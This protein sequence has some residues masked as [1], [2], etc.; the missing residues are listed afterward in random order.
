MLAC[1]EAGADIVDGALPSMA[2]LTSQPSLGALIAALE[3]SDRAIEI[4][5]MTIGEL[6]H[7]WEQVRELYLPFE[8]GLKSGTADVYDHEMPGGQY[9]NL[10]FQ[11]QSLGLSG[12]WPAVKEAYA[13]ANRVLGDVI[14]VTPTSKVVGDLAQ[15]MVQNELDEIS[16][17]EQAAQ[18]SFPTSVTDFLKGSLGHPHGGFPEPFRSR[19]LG[20]EPRIDGRPG[21]SLQPL[22]FDALRQRLEETHG[23]KMREV[24]LVSAAL[25][26]QVFDDYKR[27]N[28]DHSPLSVLSTP[29]FFGNMEPGEEAAVE[30]QPGKTLIVKY[31]TMGEAD[32]EG[33]RQVFF[34]LNG[35]PRTLLIADRTLEHETEAR[36]VA[37]R[38]KAGSV[39]APLSGA[40]TEVRVAVG[41]E[42]EVRSPLVVM[43]AMKMETVV[44]AP[45]AGKV[46]RVAVEPNATL[47][48]GDLTVEIEE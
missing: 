7:Y 17:V 6:D 40:V 34:E 5:R 31:E 4:D 19:V 12:Q 2:G 35:Q 15:F 9:T 26:P 18:L 8:S 44:A 27:A 36:E 30:I 37:D 25:Y 46:V 41:D 47:S 13:A 11:A 45:V 21:A 20:E 14:K 28:E 48:A 24:D 43:S 39:G 3:G 42:V 29:L 10:K 23:V 38:A 32:E 33:K 22:D 16:V 1:G